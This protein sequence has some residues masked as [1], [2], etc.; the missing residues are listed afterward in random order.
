MLGVQNLHVSSV[1]LVF[2][3]K[4]C[5][6]PRSLRGGLP[7]DVARPASPASSGLPY[8]HEFVSLFC[9]YQSC[10]AV[11]VRGLGG[12]KCSDTLRNC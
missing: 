4:K 6:S 2:R 7:P 8:C 11:S 5:V 12:A 3:A 1:F 9:R 10:F